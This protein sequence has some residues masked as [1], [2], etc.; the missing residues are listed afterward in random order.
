MKF[1]HLSSNRRSCLNYKVLMIMKLTFILIIASVFQ[2]VAS[3][4]AQKIT[5]SEQNAPLERVLRKLRIQ[6]G[7]DFLYNSSAIKHAKP[8]SIDVK[9]VSLQEALN[10]SLQDQPLTYTILANAV[11]IKESAAMPLITSRGTVFDEE[12]LPLAGVTVK[13]KGTQRAT[14]TDLEG[15]FILTG[16]DDNAVLQISFLGYTTKEVPAKENIGIIRLEESNSKLNEVVVIGYGTVKRGDVT[17]SV[18]TIKPTEI[19]ASKALSVDN[20]IQG[21]V[22]G[23]TVSGGVALPGSAPNITIRGANSLRGDNQPLYII[24]NIPQP[25]SGSFAQSSLGG[26]DFEIPQNPLTSISPSDIEDIQILKDASATAIYGSRGANGV[27]LITTKKGK[28]GTPKINFNTN[29]TVVGATR[30]REMLNLDEYAAFRNEKAGTADYFFKVGDEMRYVFGDETYDANNPETYNLVTG[31]NWQKEIYDNAISQAYNLSLS[32]GSDKIK[33]YL[34]GDYKD[35]NGLVKQ[36]GLKQ[37]NLRL[38]LGGNLSKNLS[39][40]TSLTGSLKSNNMMAGGNTKGGATGAITRTAIDSAPFELP[41]GDPALEGNDELR[42]TSLAWL[43]DYEDISS[44]KAL[45]ASANL[46]WKISPNF[47]YTMRGGGNLSLQERT[48][49]YDTGIWLGLNNNGYLG[50]SDLSRNNYTFENLVNYN[51]TLGKIAAVTATAGVTYDDYNWLN[52]SILASDFEFKDLGINGLHMANNQTISS[53]QQSDYQLLSYLT[54]VNFSFLDGKYILTATGRADGSSKFA[55]ENRWAFFPSA[56]VAWK[57]DKEKWLQSASWINELKLRVGYGKTGS[58]SISPYNTV[59]DYDQSRNYSTAEGELLKAI[60]VSNLSNSALKWE[61]TSAYNAGLDFDFWQGRLAGTVEVYSKKTS[62]L[63]VGKN[64]AASTGFA[65]IT[66]NQGA[67]SNKGVELSLNSE[68]IN[69]GGFTW[70][71]SG[72]IGTN[73]RKVLALGSPMMDLGAVKGNGYIGNSIGDHF[74]A[75]NIFLVGEAPGLFYGFQTDGIIQTG[76]TGLPTSTLFN[77]NPGEIRVVDVTGDGVIN[78]SDMTIIG[79]PNPDFNYGFQTALGYK[80]FKLSAA[81]YGVKGGDILNA[82]VRYEQTP[83][84]NTPNLTSF[85]YENAWRADAPSNAYPS[86]FSSVKNYV[87]DRFVEDGSFLRCSDITLGYTLPA[88]ILKNKVQDVN[89]FGSVKNAFLISDY[90]GYD[91]EMRTFSFDGLRPGI[92]LNSFSNPRQFVLG[93]NVTF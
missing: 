25:A 59:Y 2:T 65:V 72:N 48:R 11:V 40:N 83:A 58:Q 10:L 88:A 44:E 63:L 41:A 85:A 51:G 57:L 74:G 93:L 30:L 82:N 5:I 24:D 16:V 8:V 90:S 6:S 18:A 68:V 34:A 47:S 43:T 52:K 73:K 92:D 78:A 39:F 46:T 53:P 15:K 38:N 55:D 29:T 79:D 66:V 33:Y 37:G 54:R 67:L 69:S 35:I 84:A 64:I 19:E 70:N 21:K 9:S 17:G 50:Y 87:Y 12:G 60:T 7:Y 86:V 45:L 76:D 4:Y 71:L 62:D 13:I 80:R 42:T 36:T 23:V 22:A 28:A 31:H 75:A 61:T 1:Y 27:I 56:A 3:T 81:F 49:W 91:P 89:I 32:G 26:G 20:L 14:S 77:M